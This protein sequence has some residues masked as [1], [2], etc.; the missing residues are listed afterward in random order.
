MFRLV[1]LSKGVL[2]NMS[3]VTLRVSAIY[4]SNAI[5]SLNRKIRKAL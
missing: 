3:L 2:I 1:V 4:T 5:V